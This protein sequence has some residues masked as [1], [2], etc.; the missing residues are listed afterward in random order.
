MV[1]VYL[2]V[3]EIMGERLRQYELAQSDVVIYPE[4]GD[5]H[6]SSFSQAM[7][8]VDEGEKAAR[9]KLDDIRRLM[10][11]IKNWFRFRKVPKS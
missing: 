2:R 8:L 9:E 11:G 7:N 6:W 4:V 3:N 1:D 10:P 5:V